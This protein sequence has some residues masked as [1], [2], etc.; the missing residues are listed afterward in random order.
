MQQGISRLSLQSIPSICHTESPLQ[1]SNIGAHTLITTLDSVP[2]L[3]CGQSLAPWIQTGPHGFNGLGK[4]R[5]LGSIQEIPLLKC[6]ASEMT[7]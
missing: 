4:S 5:L 7:G 2:E 3:L 1:A 6:S